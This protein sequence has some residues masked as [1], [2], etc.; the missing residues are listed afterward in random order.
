MKKFYF[1]ALGLM[2]VGLNAQNKDLL[3]SVEGVTNSST[4]NS[5]L[6][7]KAAQDVL[8]QENFE[9][10][11]TGN[12]AGQNNYGYPSGEGTDADYQIMPADAKHSSKYLKINTSG[13]TTATPTFREFVEITP[14]LGNQWL[15]RKPTNNILRGELE[16]FTGTSTNT[17]DGRAGSY[18][19]DANGNGLVGINWNAKTQTLNGFLALTLIS[20]GVQG[21]YNL[22][23][24]TMPTLLPN[25]WY[26]ISYSYD[27]NTGVGTF[28]FPD[29]TDYV[30][31]N[32]SNNTVTIVPSLDPDVHEFVAFTY[33]AAA[34]AY[35]YDNAKIVAGDVTN[36]ATS[37]VKGTISNIQVYPNPTADI[38][39]VTNTKKLYSYKIYDASGKI[40]A[41]GKPE[42]VSINVS[43]L[44]K[45][46][47]VVQ[48]ITEEQGLET[49]KFIKK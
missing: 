17:G 44:Q 19:F 42:G 4:G 39:N 46:N 40:V 1:M 13:G 12:A 35:G 6:T 11:N 5:V 2:F 7:L 24:G 3:K 36:L 23:F 25:T 49:R 34:R 26:K 45:G 8:Y 48:I 20:T 21:S 32:S 41:E 22:S 27:Y 15:N 18:I 10:F 29:G 37:N 9:S 38:L 28:R 14:D 33:I 30:W 16:F 31:D 43:R 47:Y